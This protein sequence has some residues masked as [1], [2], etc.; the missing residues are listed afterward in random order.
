[1]ISSK[2]D[3]LHQF[4]T[5]EKRELGLVSPKYYAAGIGHY[6]LSRMT[7]KLIQFQMIVMMLL[8]LSY[9]NTL[10]IDYL[11]PWRICDTNYGTKVDCQE[12]KLIVE[13]G[14]MGL[15]VK[16]GVVGELN[17]KLFARST[18]FT[19]LLCPEGAT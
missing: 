2:L 1:M 11:S 18:Q 14:L 4:Q 16:L 10:C 9:G 6:D 12:F 3:T 19:T 5:S 8:K 7:L 13:Q 15:F 17:H